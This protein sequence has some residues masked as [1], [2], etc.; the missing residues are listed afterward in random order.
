MG[1]RERETERERHRES[2][3]LLYMGHGIQLSLLSVLLGEASVTTAG[4]ICL[5]FLNIS[6]FCSLRVF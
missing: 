5:L 6:A 1:E 4:R 2:V 3:R